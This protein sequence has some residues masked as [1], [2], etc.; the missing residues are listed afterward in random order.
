LHE[1]GHLGAAAEVVDESGVE[2]GFVDLEVG[3]DEQAVA[4]EALDIV[5]F[6]V[7]PSPQMWTSSSFMAATSMVPVTARPSGVVLK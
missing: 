2:P 1:R 4:V 6:E 7:E 5:A 3:I